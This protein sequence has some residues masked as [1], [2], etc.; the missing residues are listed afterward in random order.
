MPSQ[1]QPPCVF[2]SCAMDDEAKCQQS[3]SRGSNNALT[4]ASCASALDLCAE[5]IKKVCQ[6]A[7]DHRPLL[8]IHSFRQVVVS[9]QIITLVNHAHYRVIAYYTLERQHRSNVSRRECVTTDTTS[10][11][12]SCIYNNICDL[13]LRHVTTSVSRRSLDRRPR[14][15]SASISCSSLRQKSEK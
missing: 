11:R 2:T 10:R 9:N 14:R 8:P 4:I 6:M 12:Q 7:N 13:R 3:G 5:R 1:S 15:C